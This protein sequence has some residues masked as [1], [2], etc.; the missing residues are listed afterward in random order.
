VFL[1][2]AVGTLANP[3]ICCVAGVLACLSCCANGL[4]KLLNDILSTATARPSRVT[5]SEP[6]VCKMVREAESTRSRKARVAA[7]KIC[8]K[9][10]KCPKAIEGSASSKVYL[11]HAHGM[12]AAQLAAQAAVCMLLPN[13]QRENTGSASTQDDICLASVAMSSALLLPVSILQALLRCTPN[14]ALQADHR[15]CMYPMVDPDR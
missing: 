8:L 15:Y 10:L 12:A 14:V 7:T 13:A 6:S 4:A 2:F 9:R 11:I 5:R 3:R 1:P